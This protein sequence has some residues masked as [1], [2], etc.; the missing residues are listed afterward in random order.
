MLNENKLLLKDYSP[1][2]NANQLILKDSSNDNISEYYLQIIEKFSNK[3][4]STVLEIYPINEDSIQIDLRKAG[5][6]VVS[7]AFDMK[8]SAVGGNKDGDHFV[9]G[10]DFDFPFLTQR[11]DVII[12]THGC[13]GQLIS[14]NKTLKF[15]E[16]IKKLLN[17]TGLLLFEFW[18][19][20][21]V[22]KAVTDEKG[23]K[24]WEKID[25]GTEVSVMRLTK[26]KLHLATSLL[27]VDIHYIL[28]KKNTEKIILDRFNET[29]LWRLYT[30]SELEILLSINKLQCTKIFKFSSFAEPEFSSFRLLAI[31]EN[32]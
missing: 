6:T 10:D 28:E 31:C 18:H 7:T 19:L 9:I 30:I 20:P 32:S 3:K 15:L 16:K 29:H 11:F 26:S 13:F 24:D 17:P 25:S 23:H 27:H 22:E 21:G 8:I 5:L 12:L 4:V 2:K 14:Q 1:M